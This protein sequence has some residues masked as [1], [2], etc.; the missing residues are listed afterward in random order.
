M[1]H[2][3][4]LVHPAS[5]SLAETLLRLIQGEIM[6]PATHNPLQT[7]CIGGQQQA[8]WEAQWS[9]GRLKGCHTNI[10]SLCKTL[11]GSSQGCTRPLLFSVTLCVISPV[12]SICLTD[13]L[14][15]TL[16]KG[17]WRWWTG[18]YWS[19]SHTWRNDGGLLL[20]DIIYMSGKKTC[21]YVHCV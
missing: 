8:G 16:E 5:L 3:P 18:P 21:I 13:V 19:F 7:R 20:T 10:P 4:A 1:G 9:T 15:D 14:T 2:S 6:G 17:N 11:P 12:C